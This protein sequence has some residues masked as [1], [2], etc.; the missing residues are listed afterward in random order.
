MIRLRLILFSVFFVFA[1][2]RRCRYAERHGAATLSPFA[3][4]LTPPPPSP[5]ISFISIE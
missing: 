5:A 2:K 3:A 1:A 4:M